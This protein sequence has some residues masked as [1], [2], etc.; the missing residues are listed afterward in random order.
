MSMIKTTSAIF[1][2]LAFNMLQREVCPYVSLLH[3]KT[4]HIGTRGHQFVGDT[5]DSNLS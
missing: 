5:I 2:V 4:L 3:L 1:I